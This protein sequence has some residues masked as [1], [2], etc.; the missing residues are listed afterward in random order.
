MKLET[1]ETT[2]LRI[3]QFDRTDIAACARFRR[4]VFG[5]AEARAKA[6]SWLDWT[7]D[8]YR[9][10]AALGQPPYAD[11]A[12]ELRSDHRFVGSVGI[13]PTVIPWSALQGNATDTL[14]SPEIG[15]FWGIMPAHRNHGYASEAAGAL[16]EYLFVELKARQ[17]VATTENI[18][19]ASQRIME[20]LGM[21]LLHNPSSEPPW[22]Q[23]VGIIVNPGAS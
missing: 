3:R 15:M 21:K 19:I 7:I 5:V 23:V 11:Y 13:V 18:N 16:L 12:V 2:R 9:E 14:L 17:V 22:C 1:L 20:R 8:S 10:L 6:Q 4:E